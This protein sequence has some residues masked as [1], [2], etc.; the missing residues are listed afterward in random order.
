MKQTAFAITAILCLT[1]SAQG[2]MDQLEDVLTAHHEAIGGAENLKRV[3][4]AQ[5][6]GVMTIG[7]DFEASFLLTL[8]RPLRSR[9]EFTVEGRTGIQAYDGETAWIQL[10]GAAAGVARE[11]PA[12][13]TVLMAEQA[14]FEGPLIDWISKGHALDFL[15]IEELET[16]TA[17]WIRA[18]LNSGSVRDYYLDTKTLLTVRQVGRSNVQG[19]EVEIETLLGEYREVDGLM[20]PH[21]I[22]SRSPGD[23]TGQRFEVSEIEFD[24]EVS[25]ELFRMPSAG[26]GE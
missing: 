13:Q 3:K 18:T 24:V 25:D 22:D 2:Q 4:S 23:S 9:L 5:Y 14:D 12:D 15:G 26:A 10:P 8:K 6:A 7:P 16:G 20:M 19:S 1:S 21:L 17:Y 11:M